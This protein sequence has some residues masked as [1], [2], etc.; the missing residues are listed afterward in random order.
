[1]NGPKTQPTK[2]SVAEFLAPIPDERRRE[3]CKA[4]ASRRVDR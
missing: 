1:M 3:D 4:V 2:A